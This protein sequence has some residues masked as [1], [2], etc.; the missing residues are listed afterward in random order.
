MSGV[1]QNITIRTTFQELNKV[2]EPDKVLGFRD[3]FRSQKIVKSQTKCP[4]GIKIK[5]QCLHKKHLKHQL[6]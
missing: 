2:Q 5:L 6:H 4:G 3:N 1:V